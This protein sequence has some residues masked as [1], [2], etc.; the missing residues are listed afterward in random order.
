MARST[1]HTLRLFVAICPPPELTRALLVL[2]PTA[3]AMPAHRVLD[4][5]SV[6]LTLAFI[7]ETHCK[8]LRSVKESVDRSASGVPAFTLSPQR[9]ITIPTPQDGGPPRLLAVST[10]APPGLLEVQRRLAQRL[11][12]PKR[13]GRRARFLPHVTVAR[14]QHGQTSGAVDEPVEGSLATAGLATWEVR[15]VSLFSSVLTR[16]GSVYTIE[17]TAQLDR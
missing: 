17:H 15:G 2:R 5:A 6:H 7:G 1:A 13:N 3:V 8:D 9:L 12:S 16:E 14:Y 4:E 10:D 11:T